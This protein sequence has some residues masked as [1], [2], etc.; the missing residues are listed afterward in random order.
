MLPLC[1]FCVYLKLMCFLKLLL[2]HNLIMSNHKFF[3]NLKVISILSEPKEDTSYIGC[4]FY[5]L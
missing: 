4:Y 2:F 3:D 5:F 1:L